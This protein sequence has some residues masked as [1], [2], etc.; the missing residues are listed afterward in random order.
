[1]NE[2]AVA[3]TKGTQH[4]GLTFASVSSP[5]TVAYIL[6]GVTRHKHTIGSKLNKLKANSVQAKVLQKTKWSTLSWYIRVTPAVQ[7]LKQEDSKLAVTPD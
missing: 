6:H 2:A 1:M 7:G 5:H 3:L 4:C